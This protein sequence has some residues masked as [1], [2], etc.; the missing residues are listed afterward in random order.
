MM[1][2]FQLT[3]RILLPTVVFLALAVAAIQYLFIEG[4]IEGR[5]DSKLDAICDQPLDSASSPLRI[6]YTGFSEPDKRFCGIAV[7]YHSIMTPFY[8]PF[9]LEFLAGAGA[10]LLVPFVEAARDK[11]SSLFGL[12]G[13]T[14]GMLGQFG[15]MGLATPVYALLFVTSGAAARKPGPGAKI[16]QGNAEA[17]LFG[18]IV[19]WIIPTA[20]LAFL[21]DPTVTILWQ[22]FPIVMEVLQVAHRIVRPPSRLT[23]SGYYT[24]QAAYATVLVASAVLHIHY[25]WPLLSDQDTLSQLFLPSLGPIDRATAP[26][27][28]GLLDFLKWDFGIG[29]VSAFVLSL[30]FADNLFSCVVLIIWCIATTVVLGPAAAICSVLMWREEKLN[31]PNQATKV[32]KKEN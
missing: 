2:M 23:E 4:I 24:V 28:D 25:I 17:L 26:L 12:P 8:R 6:A 19:G 1:T 3:T 10:T 32:D 27:L 15:G 9:L 30:W 20:C 18:L 5:I 13:I 31:G 14:F 21:E 22:I 11:H 16:N 29:I 7:I